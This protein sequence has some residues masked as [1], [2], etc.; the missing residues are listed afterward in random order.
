V[1]EEWQVRVKKIGNHYQWLAEG[2]RQQGRTLEHA[3]HSTAL[4]F[5]S[6]IMQRSKRTVVSDLWSCN[7]VAVGVWA[8][9]FGQGTD[10][11]YRCQIASQ[12]MQNASIFKKK[13]VGYSQ[14]WYTDV[15]KQPWNTQSMQ[16]TIYLIDFPNNA[17][18]K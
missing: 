11:G 6:K 10:R 8:W 5:V 9:E 7:P 13:A 18:K 17:E 1:Q 4:H 12:A 3:R 2:R 14:V 16:N 15:R